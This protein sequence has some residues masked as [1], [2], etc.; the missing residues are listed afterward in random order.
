MPDK[1]GNRISRR[2][3]ARRAAIASA[4]GSAVASVASAAVVNAELASRAA[5]TPPS[6]NLAQ[7]VT[8]SAP[9]E[10]V[11]AHLP[12]NMAR[13]SPES[14]AEA[15]ARLHAIQV[16][17]GTRFT[18]EQK[19]DLSRLCAVVQPPLDRLR[20]YA[21]QNEDGTALYLKPLFEREK[22]PK[23]T[24]GSQPGAPKPAASSAEPASD[25]A[26]KP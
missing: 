20:A 24:A 9:S 10:P 5:Q 26:A 25:A 3:F 4:M 23:P 19:A 12:A 11:Q 22:K 8:P 6:T 16:Q 18:D 1:P 13:L 21:I 15:D 17:Y 14:L 2:E 7:S